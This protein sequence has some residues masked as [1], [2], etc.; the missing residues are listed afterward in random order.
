MNNLFLSVYVGN[1]DLAIDVTIKV[2]RVQWLQKWNKIRNLF[3][4]DDDDDDD[5]EAPPS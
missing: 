5:A 4:C 2:Y 1:D 3:L